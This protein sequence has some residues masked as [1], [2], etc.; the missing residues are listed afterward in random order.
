[1][2]KPSAIFSF[3]SEQITRQLIT[4]IVDVQV[5]V[6]PLPHPMSSTWDSGLMPALP[7]M[8]AFRLAQALR[9]SRPVEPSKIPQ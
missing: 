5:A 1:M 8:M 3:T 2:H 6:L 9:K 4:F 7:A